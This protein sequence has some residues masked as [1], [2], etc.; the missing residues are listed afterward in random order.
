VSVWFTRSKAGTFDVG[1]GREEREALRWLCS[2]LRELLT[3]ASHDGDPAVDRLYP[4]AYAPSE[5]EKNA[6]YAQ[7]MRD[8]LRAGRLGAIE[9]LESTIDVDEVTEEQLMSWMGALNDMRLVM[10]T[11]LEVTEEMDEIADDDPRAPMFGLYQYLTWL[12]SDV[13]DAI[14]EP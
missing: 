4:P 9:V 2:Q 12:Q 6:E 3:D 5:A 14:Q 13:I 1:L 11:R 7:L 10:G 8:D